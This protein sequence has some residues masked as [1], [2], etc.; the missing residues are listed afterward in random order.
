MAKRKPLRSSVFT[1]INYLIITLATLVTLY[2]FYYCVMLS[3]NDGKD[4]QRGG[5]Y[6]WPRAFTL[7]NYQQVFTD[8]LIL[9]SAQ[10]SILRT[11]LGTA[12]AVFITAMFS[13]AVSRPK[14]RFRKFY[15]FLGLATMF[16]SGGLIPYYLLIRS[17][18]LINNFLVYILPNLFAMFN[19][20]I[21]ISFF[22]TL[23]LSLEESA[24]MDG[25]ND[26]VVFLKI[27]L[28]IS[29]PVIAT[30]AL[31]VGVGQWNSWFD[32]T[33]FTKSDRL[34]TLSHLMV[35]MLN[36]AR[37]FEQIADKTMVGSRSLSQMKGLTV[38]ALQLAT[39][40]VTS[41]PIMVA[42][43]FLQKYFV[44]GVMLGSIKG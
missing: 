40:V 21:F 7:E 6:F 20:V 18:G 8:P 3:F 27:I 12:A 4:A 19:A 13:Y 22:R 9:T 2:P 14:L 25:A 1:W 37:Y 34:E 28:P 15:M 23:P 30:I 43:P 17:L 36:T 31:F 5:I 32:T 29:M 24:K 42:Y 16:F 38:N 33:L 10:T 41:F 39:M 44:Q 11:V 35:K 26:M